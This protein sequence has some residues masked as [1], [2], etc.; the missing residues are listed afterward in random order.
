MKK[1]FVA[2]LLNVVASGVASAQSTPLTLD[3]AI[4]RTLKESPRVAELRARVE[5]ARAAA[6]AAVASS[7]PQLSLQGGYTRTNHVNVFGIP[8]PDGTLRVVYPDIPDNYRARLDGSWVLYSGG[9]S[10]S[11]T[12]AARAEAQ[13]AAKELAALEAD[14]RLDVTR[15][16]WASV[17]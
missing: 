10:E 16:Y 11:L 2:A 1:L 13:A 3:E 7:K 9:R 4:A 6:D 14:L 17:T 8:L 5:G 15:A 12:A